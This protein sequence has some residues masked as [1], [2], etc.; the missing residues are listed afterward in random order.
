MLADGTVTRANENQN[1]DLYFVCDHYVIPYIIFIFS[2]A[3]RGAGASFGI[4]TEFVFVTHPEPGPTVRYSYTFKSVI[5]ILHFEMAF[6]SDFVK[7]RLGSAQDLAETFSKWQSFVSTPN[8]DRKLASTLTVT[9]VGIVIAGAISFAV[10]KRL[11]IY[12]LLRYLLW[13]SCRIRLGYPQH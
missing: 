1:A 2:Q 5:S 12:S 7:C 11:F 8:L 4:V 9:P 6:E 10:K 3:I 13:Y